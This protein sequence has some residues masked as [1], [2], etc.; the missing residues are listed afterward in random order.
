MN[1]IGP[2]VVVLA[3]NPDGDEHDGEI[4]SA[5]SF[6]DW[7]CFPMRSRRD[8]PP[9]RPHDAG[10]AEAEGT[11]KHSCCGLP[12]CHAAIADR[13]PPEERPVL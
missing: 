10:D 1:F 11:Q 13:I 12:D 5:D 8:D 4:E 3:R 7:D 2:Y 6:V 9:R